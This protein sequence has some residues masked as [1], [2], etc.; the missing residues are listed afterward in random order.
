[1]WS[2]LQDLIID[3]HVFMCLLSYVSGVNILYVECCG[4]LYVCIVIF[5]FDA[6]T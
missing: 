3:V 5:S 1:M 4:V 2:F 6:V